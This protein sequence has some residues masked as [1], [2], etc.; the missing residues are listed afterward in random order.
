MKKNILLFAMAASLLTTSCSDFLDVQPEGN[1]TT[2]QYFM[3]D[4]QAVDA[5]DG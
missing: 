1:A 3:N 4:Q 2:G 5:I